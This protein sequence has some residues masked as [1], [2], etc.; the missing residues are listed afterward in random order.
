MADTFDIL[1]KLALQVRNATLAGENSAERVGRTFVGILD[2]IDDLKNI[3]LYKNQPDETNFLVKFL[4]GLLSDYIQSVNYSSGALGEGFLIKVD[5]KTGKSYI[6]VDELFVRIKAMFSELEIKELSYAGGNYMFTSAGMKCGK[7]EEHEDF[8][9]CYLLIDD[10][11]TA[12]ENPFRVDDMVTFR[13]F[14]IKPGVYENVANRF[15][16]RLCVGVG[17]DYIDLSKTDCEA[18]NNDIPKEGDKLVQLGNKTDKAR[19]NAIT[20]SVY[21]DDAP[22][23]HQYAEIDSYSL[24]G[25]EVTVISPNGNKFIGDFILKTGTNIATQL[26]VLENLIMTEIQSVEYML[27]ER[28]N[29]LYNATFTKDMEGWVGED[30]FEVYANENL[31]IVNDR[32][33]S[34]TDKI[35]G[36]MPRDGKLWLRLK[37]SYVIQ[38]NGNILRPEQAGKFYVSFRYICTETGTISCGFEGGKMFHTTNISTTRNARLF[39]FSGDWDGIGDFLIKFTGD[40]YINLVAL[41]NRPLDDYKLEVSSKLKQLSD[42][43]SA[44]VKSVNTLDKTIK[45]SGFLTTADGTKIWASCEFSNGVKAESLFNI[46]KD[47]ISLKSEYIKLEGIVTANENFK[48]NLDGSIEAKNGTFSGTLKGATGEFSGS[49][50]GAN[51]T[52]SGKLEAATGEFRGTVS[53]AN[54][55]IL[56]NSDGSGKLAN[57]KISWDKNGDLIVSS[58]VILEGFSQSGY[59]VTAVKVNENGGYTFYIDKRNEYADSVVVNSTGTN[60]TFALP[61]DADVWMGRTLYVYNISSSNVLKIMGI[62]KNIP[63][64]GCGVFLG[65]EKISSMMMRWAIISISNGEG[66]IGYVL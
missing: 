46:L 41:T 17:E 35:A 31:L 13:D 48:V 39:E 45:E 21:G 32:L 27:N 44:I 59:M 47:S 61:G 5:S 58:S 33:L 36:V 8:W 50:K 66:A 19:Q 40:I 62:S 43:I 6:E 10:G 60:D 54:G 38:P 24:A 49:L 18:P 26:Q 52:F 65:C 42:S 30:S 14:N 57:G 28:E 16:W 15:Y 20:L 56:L 53:I 1:R 11:E 22:S 23:I 25:K 29:F 2:L 7:V 64:G 4:G 12:I 37:N 55:S 3:Y 34:E 63:A 9:R 51:G